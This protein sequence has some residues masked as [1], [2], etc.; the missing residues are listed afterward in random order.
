TADSCNTSTGAVSHTPVAAGTTC[1]DANLC[2]GSETCN[3]TGTCVAG[4]PVVTDDS[5]PCTTD[6]CNTTTGAVTHGPVARGTSCGDGNACTGG[7]RCNS[8]GTCV[9]GTPIVTNDNN[10]CTTDT[11]NSS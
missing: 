2:N 4:T 3:A 10:P 6:A 1:A 7:E 8:P 9:P 11:C 5:N